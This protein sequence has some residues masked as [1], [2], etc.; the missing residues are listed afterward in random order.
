MLVL[1]LTF[2]KRGPKGEDAVFACKQGG[3]GQACSNACDYLHDEKRYLSLQEMNKAE[4][5]MKAICLAS[6][7]ATGDAD[8]CRL[9]K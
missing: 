4:P 1:S 2:C 5:E 6:C 8:H 9:A 7:S 3:N